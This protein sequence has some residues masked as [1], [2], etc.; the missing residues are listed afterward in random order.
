MVVQSDLAATQGMLVV[1]VFPCT[2]TSNLNK[3]NSTWCKDI[4]EERLGWREKYFCISHRIRHLHERHLEMCL[5]VL[6]YRVRKRYGIL[7]NWKMRY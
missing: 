4:S 2:G 1:F 7:I 5:T 6:I 3:S